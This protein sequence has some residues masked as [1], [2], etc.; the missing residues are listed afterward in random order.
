MPEYHPDIETDTRGLKPDYEYDEV[1]TI[2]FQR[3]ESKIGEEEGGLIILKCW[4]PSEKDILERFL[5]PFLA[6]MSP[7]GLCLL[8]LI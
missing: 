1:L 6:L 7:G 5:T 4:E 3:L 8:D 2:Q